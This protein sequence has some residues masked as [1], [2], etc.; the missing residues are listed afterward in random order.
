[1]KGLLT[2]RSAIASALAVGLLACGRAPMAS[3]A[4]GEPAVARIQAFY[5]VLL[6]V[7]KQADKLG[8]KGRVEKLEPVIQATFDSATMARLSVGQAWAGFTPEQQQAISAAFTAM[9]VAS[10]A[11]E[12]NGYSGESFVVEPVARARGA[13]HIVESKIMRTDGDPVQL[14]YLMRGPADQPKIVDIYLAGTISQIAARR[15]EFAATI[16]QGGAD[17]LLNSMKEQTAALL[18]GKAKG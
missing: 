18:S 12:F 8:I 1:M 2:R 16:Q 7:M 15:S 3:A 17:G 9:T 11:S 10:Y 4:E 13:D 5:D 14:N 6:S